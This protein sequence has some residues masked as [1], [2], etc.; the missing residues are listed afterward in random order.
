MSLLIKNKIGF[1]IAG[2]PTISDKY[3]VI[4][5]V[6]GDEALKAG[7]IVEYDEVFK[8]GSMPLVKPVKASSK[9]VGVLMHQNVKV[10]LGHDEPQVFNPGDVVGICVQGYVTAL[11]DKTFDLTAVKV[12]ETTKVL[13]TD[14]TVDLSDKNIILTGAQSTLKDSKLVE[15]EVVRK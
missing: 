9:F 1:N 12:D 13:K 3:D 6:V 2:A 11:A 7:Q 14:G 10:T 5:G 8:E 15:V 4:S